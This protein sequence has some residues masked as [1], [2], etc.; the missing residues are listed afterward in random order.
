MNDERELWEVRV[1]FVA[2][3]QQAEQLKEQIAR[4]LCPEPD[5]APPCRLPWQIVLSRP[6]DTEVYESVLIQDRIEHR[7]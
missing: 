3:E 2:T 1:G 6:D 7:A 4:L 5:H